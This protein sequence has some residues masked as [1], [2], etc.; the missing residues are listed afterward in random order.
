MMATL[1]NM[2]R[3]LKSMLSDIEKENY[4]FFPQSMED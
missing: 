2:S 1:K 4:V 3:P